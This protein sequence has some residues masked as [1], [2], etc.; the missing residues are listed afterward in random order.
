L[1]SFAA[2]ASGVVRCMAAA[3]AAKQPIDHLGAFLQLTLDAPLS[4]LLPG[5]LA[6]EA[7]P[8]G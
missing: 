5:G 1:G 4:P 7:R 6:Q 3:P 2:A 8:G